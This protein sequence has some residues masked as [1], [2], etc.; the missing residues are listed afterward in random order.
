M[1]NELKIKEVFQGLTIIE[2]DGEPWFFS[3]E[4]YKFLGY[5]WESGAK[6]LRKYVDEEDKLCVEF[7]DLDGLDFDLSKLDRSNSKARR[8]TLISE[9]GLYSLTLRAHT[10]LAKQFSSFVTHEVL[11]HIRKYGMYVSEQL[12]KDNK[13]LQEQLTM[14]KQAN[15]QQQIIMQQSQ[16]LLDSMN[17]IVKNMTPFYNLADK[18]L[19][20]E[21]QC[22]T[23]TDIGKKLNMSAR[24]INT[25]LLGLG[26]IKPDGKR[27]YC[28]VEPNEE[29][30]VCKDV[31]SEDKTFTRWYW[32]LKGEQFVIDTIENL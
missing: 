30:L 28:L 26:I 20:V 4:V 18:C 7:N 19:K 25:I 32:T 31:T 5:N 24:K 15:E 23:T 14:Y 16:R 17:D 27:G 11:P 1:T 3:S 29:L 6:A 9:A 13:M 21:E 12:L 10:P 8:V 22:I 2:R